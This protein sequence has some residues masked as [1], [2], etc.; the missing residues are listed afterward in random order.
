MQ[1]TARVNLQPQKAE[2]NGHVDPDSQKVRFT[3]EIEVGEDHVSC[4]NLSKRTIFRDTI[5]VI[6]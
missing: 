4:T 2:I 5:R 1:L 6:P 3:L